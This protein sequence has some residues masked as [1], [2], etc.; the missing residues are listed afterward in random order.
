MEPRILGENIKDM[1]GQKIIFSPLERRNDVLV[2]LP[3]DQ[4]TK[5]NMMSFF[6]EMQLIFPILTLFRVLDWKLQKISETI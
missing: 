4:I 1:F 3:D 6:L 2:F 5:E